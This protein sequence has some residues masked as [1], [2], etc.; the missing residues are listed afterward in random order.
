MYILNIL[1]WI[2]N[3]RLR[4]SNILTALMHCVFQ[5]CFVVRVC[6]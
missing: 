6:T 2:F 5:L 3:S 1:F 4:L